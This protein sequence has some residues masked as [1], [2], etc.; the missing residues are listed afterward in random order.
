[1][2]EDTPLLNLWDERHSP[3]A[4][5]A[6]ARQRGSLPQPD[7][8]LGQSTADAP[9]VLADGAVLKDREDSGKGWVLRSDRLGL[10]LIDCGSKG[11][12]LNLSVTLRYRWTADT[13]RLEGA[14]L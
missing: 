9:R 3:P 7:F 4:Q 6:G 5:S 11:K 14:F 2:L 1:M 10:I 12:L 13:P 8:C